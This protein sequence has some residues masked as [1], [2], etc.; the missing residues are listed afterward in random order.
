MKTAVCYKRDIKRKRCLGRS[1][2]KIGIWSKYNGVVP[3]HVQR[4]RQID[5]K[6]LPPPAGL[7]VIVM[8]HLPVTSVRT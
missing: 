8:E 5:S 7:D 3:S 4:A 6:V 1:R 2:R